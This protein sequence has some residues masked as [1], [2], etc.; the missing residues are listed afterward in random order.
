MYDIIAYYNGGLFINLNINTPI[1]KTIKFAIKVKELRKLFKRS[2]ILYEI[3]HVVFV[4]MLKLVLNS[5][6]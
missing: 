1:P 6:G 3:L 2:Y 5:Y 4:N